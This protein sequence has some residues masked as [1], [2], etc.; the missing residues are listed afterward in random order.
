[1]TQEKNPKGKTCRREIFIY[2]FLTNINTNYTE[3]NQQLISPK[4][5]LEKC[6]N[7][8]KSLFYGT[9]LNVVYNF[10]IYVPNLTIR[11]PLDLCTNLLYGTTMS[12]VWISYRIVWFSYLEIHD[13]LCLNFHANILLGLHAPSLLYDLQ[14][15]LLYGSN[16]CCTTTLGSMHNFSLKFV[17]SLSL[18]F[19]ALLAL[20]FMQKISLGFMQI[21]I[22]EIFSLSSTN[23][24]ILLL[25]LLFYFAQIVFFLHPQLVF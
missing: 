17:L 11:W 6:A 21:S 13:V 18:E 22:S 10:F 24:K 14:L 1:M 12:V 20:K 7:D 15:M 8:Q 5:C 23:S 19:R 25:S 3:K 2:S 16:K 9:T 4:F